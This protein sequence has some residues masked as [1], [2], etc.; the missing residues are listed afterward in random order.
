MRI[1]SWK[2][3]PGDAS[4]TH[5]T[6][7]NG[8]EP[9]Q[10]ASVQTGES[11]T[12]VVLQRNPHLRVDTLDDGSVEWCETMRPGRHFGGPSER[13]FRIVTSATATEVVA[14]WVASAFEPCPVECGYSGG[15]I[16]REILCQLGEVTVADSQC[17]LTKPAS[18]QD[19]PATA[20]CGTARYAQK[21]G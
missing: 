11:A 7:N 21:C 18:S 17:V 10:I 13:S 8:Y 2:G 12:Y 20:G 4:D 5:T 6:A 9:Y 1:K 14:G 3:R 19:C 16:E 15:A